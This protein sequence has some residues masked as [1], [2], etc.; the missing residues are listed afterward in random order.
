MKREAELARRNPLEMQ[1]GYN[2]IMERDTIQEANQ[3]VLLIE[4]EMEKMREQIK[5]MTKDREK[6]FGTEPQLQSMKSGNGGQDKGQADKANRRDNGRAV[7]TVSEQERNEPEGGTRAGTRRTEEKGVEP[8]G[9]AGAG[10]RRSE[11]SGAGAE[12]GA[13]TGTRKS[14]G[15]EVGVAGIVTEDGAVTK[16]NNGGK[17]SGQG[18]GTGLAGLDQ[19]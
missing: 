16:R 15:N 14:E 6:S 5:N 17:T 8:E 2:R 7:V 10:T 12:G 3:R 13:R 9:G 19:E 1:F 18:K 4:I 11:E